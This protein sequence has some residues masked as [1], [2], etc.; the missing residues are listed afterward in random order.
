M[1]TKLAVVIVSG[2]VAATVL[3]ARGT[4]T[5]PQPG[6]SARQTDITVSKGRSSTPAKAHAP[7]PVKPEPIRYRGLVVKPHTDATGQELRLQQ[8]IGA[9]LSR[10]DLIPSQRLAHC[11]WLADFPF[12]ILTG[13]HGTITRTE[14][15]QEG[16]RVTMEIYP[17]HTAGGGIAA[18]DDPSIETYLYSGG[19]VRFLDYKNKRRDDRR[20]RA[21][22]F[23]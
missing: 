20:P 19:Q 14:V 4:E 3:V 21:I 13:W 8:E 2:L 15:V 1:R 9:V 12:I 22:S 5:P 11:A 18:V 17:M 6:S 7:E 23:N 16:V 10:L